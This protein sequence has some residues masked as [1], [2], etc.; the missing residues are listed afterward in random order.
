M[1]ADLGALFEHD[2]LQ[3]GIDLLQFDRRREARYPAADQSHR[4][5]RALIHVRSWGFPDP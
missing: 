4:H 2:S 1:R 5:R 3:I